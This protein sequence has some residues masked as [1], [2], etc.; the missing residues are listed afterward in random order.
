MTSAGTPAPAGPKEAVLRLYQ[1]RAAMYDLE[2]SAFEPL[3][4][5]A[6][7][8]LALQT[9]DGVLDVG[10]GTGLSFSALE[11]RIGPTGRITGIEQSP[12]MLERARQ[13]VAQHQWG[14]IDLIEDAAASAPLSGMADAMLLHFT[15]DIVRQPAALT[16]LFAH[17][18]PGARVVS[19]G[20]KWAPPWCGAVNLYV[21]SAALYSVSSLEGLEEPWSLLE[22]HLSDFSMVPVMWGAGYVACGRARPTPVRR[23]T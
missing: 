5:Q 6:I 14:N 17:L 10:C 2:L 20:L 18:K 7:D 8:A 19:T 13:R 9:G 1:H 3:R 16:H 23:A 15:H 12:D 4:Q 11:D 21:L 22:T